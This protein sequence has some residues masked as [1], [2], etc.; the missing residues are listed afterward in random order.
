MHILHLNQL[1]N[2]ASGASRYFSEVGVRLVAE[3]HCVT[4]LSSNALDLEYFWDGRRRQVAS[5]S[6][7]H[8]GVRLLRL[9]V[10]RLPGPPI[11]YP[12]LRRL[13]VEVSRLGRRATPLLQRMA[14]L[15]PRLG[16]LEQFLN[17]DPSLADVAVVHST[18]ITL[19]FALMPVAHWAQ[20]R[21]IAHICT[22]F[23]HLGE[24]GS[25]QIIQYYSMPHQIAML[26]NCSA[27]ATMTDLERTFLIRQ[28]VHAERVHVVG[29]GVDPHEVGG[30]DATRFRT[31]HA[32]RGPIVLSLGAAA[33]D[34]GT[35]HVLAALRQ[36][37][38]AGESVT[39]V[40]CGPLLGH[41]EHYYAQLTPAERAHTR[42]LGYVDNQTRRDALAAATI[43][44]QPS[45]TDS[46]GIAYLEAWCYG[47]PV[48]GAR[49]GGVPAVIREGVDGMLVAFGDV[50]AL[51][52]ILRRLLHDH[53]LAR[54]LGAVGRQRVLREFTWDA[55]Y[56]RIRKL[57]EG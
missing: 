22:P 8:D 47:V 38:A 28:G 32:I 25:R 37:W 29:A 7:W 16:Q 31:T 4:L 26:H 30:G 13:M 21:G 3:G 20:Q 49:A 15:T 42:L 52:Q 24:P 46:F 27:V 55:A 11:V 33:Y 39:W 43:Y 48:I 50:P 19:D 36:L 6:T 23:I 17:H 1:Y 5:G 53:E 12:V 56:G 9:P 18:N 40:Q 41:F 34:K 45:R 57:Y 44:A 35:V 10:Q 54:A 2:P 51:A 14:T